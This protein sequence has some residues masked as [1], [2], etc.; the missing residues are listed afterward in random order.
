[1]KREEPI[2]RAVR[3]GWNRYQSSF[4]DTPYG[5]V[6]KIAIPIVLGVLLLVN[7]P[8]FVPIGILLGT[9]YLVYYGLRLLLLGDPLVGP[10]HWKAMQRIQMEK[11]REQCCKKS[12]RMRIAE[13]SGS[14]LAAAGCIVPLSA[15]VA[16][17]TQQPTNISLDFWLLYGWMT[18]TAI[19]ASW[20]MLICGKWWERS[21]G[22]SIPR[23]MALV[24][25]GLVIGAASFG[26]SQALNLNLHDVVTVRQM[27]RPIDMPVLPAFMVYFGGLM[28]LP[29]W[30]RSVDPLRKHRVSL[31]AAA[32]AGFWAYILHLLLAFPLP[33]G[34]LLAL[35]ISL[36]VQLSAPWIDY[37]RIPPTRAAA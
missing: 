19:G 25:I 1:V 8:V 12:P 31:L 14:M 11:A 35:I 36:A 15:L 7:A 23:R 4:E 34:V 28:A 32:F 37:K 6:I 2:A 22:Q 17:A 13:L 10:S 3:Q 21:D 33:L 9:L 24:V 27:P 20:L 18:L 16:V 29:R 5:S 30:W 26:L